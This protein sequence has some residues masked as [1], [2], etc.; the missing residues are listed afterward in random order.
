M[1]VRTCICTIN[2]NAYMY[3]NMYVYKYLRLYKNIHMQSKTIQIYVVR[4][5]I[6]SIECKNVPLYCVKTF[7]GAKVIKVEFCV[8]MQLA[9]NNG[10]VVVQRLTTSG[11]RN[12]QTNLQVSA[13]SSQRGSR[14]NLRIH[15]HILTELEIFN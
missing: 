15:T 3:N 4:K 6:V 11:S 5:L 2:L 14:S 9:L 12:A 13:A 8:K 1:S 7:S 10:P